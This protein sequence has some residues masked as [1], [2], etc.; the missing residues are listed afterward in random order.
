[1]YTTIVNSIIA[2][3]L[4]YYGN[5]Y[6]LDDINFAIEVAL[7]A[8]NITWSDGDYS[9]MFDDIILGLEHPGESF[10]EPTKSSRF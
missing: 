8:S 2:L 1:M 3:I 5:N 9:D 7:S 6:S 10:I 4:K